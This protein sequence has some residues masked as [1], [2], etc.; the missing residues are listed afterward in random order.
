MPRNPYDQPRQPVPPRGDRAEPPPGYPA[1][2]GAAPPPGYRPHGGYNAAPAPGPGAPPG[3]PPPGW[4]PAPAPRPSNGVGLAGFIC[5]LVGLLVCLPLAPVGLVLSIFGLRRE[6]R[7]FAIAGLVLGLLGTLP[8]IAFIVLIAFMGG[9]MAAGGAVLA[10]L[11][12]GQLGAT[13]E[14][15]Q[16]AAEL[17]Q[18][19]QRQGS[20][21]ADL[22]ALAASDPD[23]VED[24]W[25][26]PYRYTLSADAK[27]F[28]LTSDGPDKAPGTPDDVNF[29]SKTLG[30]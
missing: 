10:S 20:Y 25:G 17:I 4:I 8:V 19:R 21:P 27:S 18:Q 15:G 1:P 7:G 14:M 24:P 3:Y 5:S 26:S 22:A 2:Q 23:L 13:L 11:G 29:S 28:T 12:A 30:Y 16:I 6:P 9:I